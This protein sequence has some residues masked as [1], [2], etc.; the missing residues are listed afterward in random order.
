MSDQQPGD[1]VGVLKSYA[2]A[3]VTRAPQNAHLDLDEEANQADNK[4]KE[5]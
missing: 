4:E 5:L 1:V 3:S 2:T